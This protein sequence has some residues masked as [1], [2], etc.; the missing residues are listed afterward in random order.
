MKDLCL[1]DYVCL[2]L[3]KQGALYLHLIKKYFSYLGEKTI[4][5]I[6]SKS[7]FS[8]FLHHLI[9]SLILI[10]AFGVYIEDLKRTKQ[11]IQNR[12]TEQQWIPHRTGLEELGVYFE[13]DLDLQ[14]GLVQISEKQTPGRFYSCKAFIRGGTCEQKWA[15]SGRGWESRELGKDGARVL[16]CCTD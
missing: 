8:S 13:A 7:L 2:P 15:C 9:Y 14:V 1:P 4:L 3:F 16:D 11:N 6:I 12:S 5:R 10:L